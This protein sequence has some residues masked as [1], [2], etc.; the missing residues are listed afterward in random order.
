MYSYTFVLLLLFFQTHVFAQT[1]GFDVITAPTQDQ[2]VAAGSILNIVWEPSASYSG[3][4]TLQLLEGSTPA[5][6]AQGDVIV[7][8]LRIVFTFTGVQNSAGQYSWSIPSG[9]PSFATYGIQLFLDSDKTVFQYSFPFHITKSASGTTTVTAS[10]ATTTQTPTPTP[11]Q[12]QTQTQTQTQTTTQVVATHSASAQS[13]SNSSPSSTPTTSANSQHVPTS[14]D[15]LGS[16]TSSSSASSQTTSLTTSNTPS[17]IL[18]DA[19]SSS[20]LSTSSSTLGPASTS[21]PIV[22]NPK[23]GLTKS[24]KIGIGIGVAFGVALIVGIVAFAFWWGM[25]AAGKKGKDN[26]NGDGNEKVE[27]GAGEIRAR[28]LDGD[29]N[30]GWPLADEEKA[31]L[32]GV[33][34][35]NNVVE[36]GIGRQDRAELE[37]RRRFEIG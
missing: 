30:R 16:G 19:S 12:S 18:P 26:D 6:L 9:I 1:A 21:L 20:L 31:E 14:T 23:S 35:I 36:M 24:A 22:A 34:R 8:T 17:T 27:L 32:D 3:T 4:V 2:N 13:P 5:T 37:G 10:V 11:S 28:E 33:V 7:G 29:V 15:T 25:R